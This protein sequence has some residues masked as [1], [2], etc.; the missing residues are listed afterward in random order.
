MKGFR[1][2]INSI[3]KFSLQDFEPMLDNFSSK[4]L[5]P[6]DLRMSQPKDITSA[7]CSGLALPIASTPNW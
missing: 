6:N 7:S 1:Y 5:I 4:D 2:F 3:L